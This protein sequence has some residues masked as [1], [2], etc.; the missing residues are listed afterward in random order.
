MENDI[1]IQKYLADCGLMSRRAAER[2]I[3]DGYVTVNG[4]TASLGQ[5]VTPLKDRVEYHGRVVAPKRGAHPTYLMLNKP[6]GYITT[7]SDDKGRRTVADLVAGA[8]A[9][10]YPVGRLD[11]DSEGLLLFTN[12]GMLANALT[13]PSHALPKYYDVTLEGAVTRAHLTALSSEMEIDGYRIRPVECALVKRNEAFSV[14][15]MILFEG[16]NRQIRKMCE[17]VGLT[18]KKLRRIAIGDLTLD[19]ARGKWRY[20]NKEEVDYL[21]EATRQNGKGTR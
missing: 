17:Q 14:V 7:M 6:A 9:R 21:K 1:K 19:V 10:V 13:H 20:L 11:M 18:V 5:R 12:D 15:R 4:E 2:E 3:A 16:R 8:E